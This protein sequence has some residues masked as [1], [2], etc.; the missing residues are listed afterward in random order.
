MPKM[1]ALEWD[2][3]EAR[4]AVASVRTGD[5]TVEDAFIVPLG[6]DES[7]E[8]ET[9]RRI[10]EALASRNIGR[11]DTLVALGR[12]NLELRMMSL[13]PAAAADRPDLVRFQ[14]MHNF[15]TIGDDWPLD[16]VEIGGSDEEG[17]KVLAG[18]I[19][20]DLKQQILTTCRQAELEPRRLV[21][22]PFAAAY[23]L[24]R[25]GSARSGCV[26]MVDR[27]AQEA[28][29]SVLVDGQVGFMRTVRLPVHGDEATVARALFGEIRRTIGAAQNQLVGKKVERLVLCGSPEGHA[30]LVAALTEQLE[31]PVESFDPFQHV[32]L[33]SSLTR[34]QPEQSGRFAPLLGMLVNEADDVRHDMDYL[35]PR[36]R[37]EPP[38]TRNRRLVL[39]GVATAAVLLVAFLIWN[40]L[41]SLDS[42]IAELGKRS[43]DMDA[44]VERADQL[45]RESQMLEQFSQGDVTWLDELR[46]MAVRVPSSNSTMLSELTLAT[47]SP[48]G[49]FL[50][51][52]HVRDSSDIIQLEQSLRYNDNIVTGKV[53]T[54]D[55]S[56]SEYAWLFD[57]QGFVNADKLDNARSQGRPFGKGS[58][59]GDPAPVNEQLEVSDT[60]PRIPAN[61]AS[62][63]EAN[64]DADNAKRS[65][66]E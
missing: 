22:R 29:L 8:S 31:F 6:D 39:G 41:R 37:P 34:Q 59:P 53:G 16:Y 38:N 51:K 10:A 48:G 65:E 26:L 1:L 42:E 13:P 55:Q 57:T 46:E 36:R 56:Q 14:A 7:S 9:G 52:G 60:G 4:V 66:S 63:D 11:L 50:M 33:S 30:D 12:A 62:T 25:F 43:A 47:N 28:D 40:G 54:L 49:A 23:L 15:T 45:V 32:A 58:Q 5:I 17:V 19:T 24:R 21:L 61:G 27:L 3:R 20:P 18:V 35:N 2:G 44:A 64:A